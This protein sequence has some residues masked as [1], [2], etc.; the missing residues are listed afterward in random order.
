MSPEHIAH[1]YPTE[2]EKAQIM[3]DTGIELK[4]LTNWFVNNRKR[5][6]KPRVEAKLQQQVQTKSP[7]KSARLVKATSTNSLSQL[8][9][10]VSELAEH[11]AAVERR[12]SRVKVV[13]Q[14]D[15]TSFQPSPR[16]DRHVV[17]DASSFSSSESASVFSSTEEEFS[18]EDMNE[19]VSDGTVSRSEKVDVHVLRP[20]NGSNPSIADVTILPNVPPERI[21]CTYE[22][23]ELT[24]RFP[25]D[26]IQDRKK[27]RYP[28]MF[29]CIDF[30]VLLNS[31]LTTPS[32]CLLVSPTGSKPS[33][34]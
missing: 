8:T 19:E 5:F 13:G 23:C 3:A 28:V 20:L 21:L 25:V 12:S 31:W 10:T 4:Q 18:A 26:S 32:S 14:D 7:S 24:Y 1:P 16:S 2:Q 27:V 30:P 9:S 22:N 34:L 11:P 29:C 6:W 15:V 17:S 33:R